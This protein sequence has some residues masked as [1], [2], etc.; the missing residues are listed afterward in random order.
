M[1]PAGRQRAV[2]RAAAYERVSTDEQASQGFSLAAQDHRIRAYCESKGWRLVR[3]YRDDGHTGLDLDRAQYQRMIAEARVYDVI[4]FVKL[5]RL[6]RHR[7]NFD[8]FVEWARDHGKG[9]AAI[10]GGYDTTTAMGRFFVGLIVDLAHLES[11]QIGE[12][13]RPA[14][15]E[16]KDAGIPQ[17]REFLGFEFVRSPDGKSGS[18]Q[19]TLWGRSLYDRFHHDG[20]EAARHENPYPSG[21]NQGKIPSRTA[22][23]RVVRNFRLYEEGRLLANRQRTPAGSHSKFPEARP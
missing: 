8:D 1:D 22:A 2:V 10:E 3:V 21:K 14:M 18:Y 5:D 7:R 23:Y 9:W 19:P 12:R 13:V 11:E 20:V 6:H 17:G 16:A 4:V 15:E